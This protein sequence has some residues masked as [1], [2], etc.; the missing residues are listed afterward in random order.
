[1]PLSLKFEKFLL[2]QYFILFFKVP[3]I[4]VLLKTYQPY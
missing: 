3:F 1:M 4:L 2:K